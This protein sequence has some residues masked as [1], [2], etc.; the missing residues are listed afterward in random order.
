MVNGKAPGRTTLIV[1][2][3]GAPPARW[4][5]SVTKDTTDFEIF[6]R[7]IQESCGEDVHVAGAGETV[8]LTGTVKSAADSKRAASLASTRAKTVV[9]LIQ[10]PSSEPRQIMLQ[11]KFATI[12]RAALART[13]IQL[14]QP[15]PQ[16]LGRTR[17]P[18]VP[19]AALQPLQFQDQRPRQHHGEFRR[20][21]EP[22]RLP[23][24]PEHRR[25]HSRHAAAAT[26]CRFSPSPT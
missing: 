25:H 9:N 22:V 20:P 15:Q 1:W 10:S 21:A 4:E 19:V 14:L 26:C 3:T 6:A 18:A 5:V 23:A 2:E 24:R 16:L 13:R 8:V 7:Q 17:H 12:D 11:V